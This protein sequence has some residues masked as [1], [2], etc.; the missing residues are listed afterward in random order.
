MIIINPKTLNFCFIVPDL[1]PTQG[2]QKIL[3]F[4][5]GWHHWTSIRLGIR[6]EN[7]YCVLYFY[8]YLRGKRIVKRL[9]KVNVAESVRVRISLNA[10]YASVDCYANQTIIGSY[11]ETGMPKFS[12]PPVGYLLKPYFETDEP[13]NKKIPLDV[14]IFNVRVNGKA[15]AW[16]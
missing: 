1:K 4:S 5:R 13:E 14:I 16:G 15:I 3:G 2:V 12:F 7:D 8:A 11:T 10:N 9:C 6:K